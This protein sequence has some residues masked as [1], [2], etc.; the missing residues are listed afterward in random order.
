MPKR[1]AQTKDNNSPFADRTPELPYENLGSYNLGETNSDYLDTKTVTPLQLDWIE[2]YTSGKPLYIVKSN[3]EI[4]Y[5]SV[6]GTGRAL[7]VHS[8]IPRY[9]I[10][11]GYTEYA[12]PD[13]WETLSEAIGAHYQV[14]PL[15]AGLAES[16]VQAHV[17]KSRNPIWLKAVQR[18]LVLHKKQADN[19]YRRKG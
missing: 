4:L 14:I 17:E 8:V 2:A 16:S 1:T 11:E 13:A 18:L 6:D 15:E 5:V 12:G 7:T 3:G 10:Q 19:P 9:E